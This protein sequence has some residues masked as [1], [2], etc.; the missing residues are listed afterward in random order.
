MTEIS[1]TTVV[2]ALRASMKQVERLRTE[3][4]ELRAAQREPIAIVGMGCRYP[5]GV[6]SADQLWEL[7]RDGRD[8]IGE[9]PTDRG[10]EI[11]ELFDPE[12][13]V[14][15]KTYTRWGGF[16]DGAGD[17][18]AGFFGISPREALGMDPQ[19]RLLLE[20]SWE[21][22]E[23][24][25]IDPQRLRGTNTGVFAGLAAFDRYGPGGFGIPATAASVVSGRVAYALG[26]A[27]PAISVDTACS[28]S[29]VALHLA[30]GSLRSGECE[31]ALAGGVT[32]MAT[33]EIFV[34]FSRQRGLSPDGRCRS[35]GARAEGTGWGEGAGVVVLERLSRARELGH[36][37]LGMVTG[38]AV[39][40]DGASNGLTAPNGPAQQRV[41]RAALAAAGLGIGDVDVVEGHGTATRLG[42][43]VEI[44]AL[45]AT[46]G[47]RGGSASP[48]WLGSVKSNV[49]H[50]QAAAG[51]AG[52]IKMVQAMRHGVL[53][54]SLHCE[55]PSP[56][57]DW[58]SGN[59][60][61]L[62]RARDW[63]TPEGR[64]RRAGV[65]SFGISGTN[66]H[67]ILEQ[68]P[69]VAP[70]PAP[71]CPAVLEGPAAWALSARSAAALAGQARRL[72]EFATA[73]I[74]L[75]T[76]AIGQALGGRA[77][78]EHRA[79]VF[80]RARDELL[81]ALAPLADD[82][83]TGPD[84][85]AQQLVSGTAAVSAPDG[86][87]LVFGGQGSQW[88]GMGRELLAQSPVFAASMRDCEQALAPHVDWSLTRVL[89][90]EDALARVDVVQPALWAVMVS[91]AR[92]WQAAGVRVGAVVGH[93]QGEI[94]AACVA[95]VLS[96]PDAA[97]VVALRARELRRLA[98]TGGMVAVQASP[99]EVRA[100]LV[101]G[102]DIAAVNGPQSVVVSGELEPLRRF[103]TTA[104][105]AGLRVRWLLVDY[106]A[107][108]ARIDALET[109]LATALG[110]IAPLPGS[111]ELYSTV[112]GSRIAATELDTAYWI[113]NLRR[114]VLFDAAVR[115]LLDDGY[116]TFLE[117]SPH[118]LLLA[119]ITET[120][121]EVD[122]ALDGELVTVGSLR[123]GDGSADALLRNLAEAFVSG[124]DVDWAAVCPSPDPRPVK[125]PTYAFDRQ[126]Y[127]LPATGPATRAATGATP[128]PHPLLGVAVEEPGSGTVVLTG[129]WSAARHPWLADHA[130]CGQAVFPATGFVDLA[131]A[132]G[133]RV[134][135]PILRELDVTAALRIPADS[136]ISVR[137]VLGPPGAPEPSTRT[138]A[139]HS[140]PDVDGAAEEWM[141]NAE[142]V[143]AQPD[144]PART[145]T[146]DPIW[147]PA[148]AR[149][150]PL[151]DFYSR[152]AARGYEYGP[153]FQRVAGLWQRGEE[154]FAEAELL[155]H[156]ATE[157]F[158][159]HPALF[160][161]ILHAAVDIAG[162]D[163]GAIMLPF[164][165]HGV[166]LHATGATRVRAHIR[167]AGTGSIALTVTDTAGQK[168][169]SVDSLLMRPLGRTDLLARSQHAAGLFGLHWVPSTPGPVERDTVTVV[170]V[171]PAASASPSGAHAVVA[172][173]LEQVRRWLA[174]GTGCL[175]VVT[176]GAVAAPGE[177]VTD[178]AGAAVWGLV[179][180]AR[181]E[182]SARLVLAD[183]DDWT[184][185]PQGLPQW[186]GDA[187]REV[188]VRGGTVYV[189]RVV[190]LAAG[191][192][193]PELA[194]GTV[195]I[196]GGTG[197]L[198][199][200]IARH[201]V[202]RHGVRR[203]VL[204]SRRGPD[205]DGADTVAA[206]L[207]D[208]GARVRVVSCD[209][210]Q[211]DSVRHLLAEIRAHD[212]LAGVVHAAGVLD[213]GVVESLSSDR[214]AAVL[215]P[216]VDGA[217]HLH[218]WTAD[219]PPPLFAL[220]SSA[221][222]VLGSAGQAAY[223]AAN[224]FLDGLASYRRAQG[225]PAVSVAW[226]LWERA[227]GM[228][229]GLG[230]ADRSRIRR[231]G[232]APMSTDFGSAV[233][234]AVIAADE[235]AVLGVRWDMRALRAQSEQGS[236]PSLFGE[237]V[238]STRPRATAA[239]ALA[240][241]RDRLASM[242]I[243]ERLAVLL[244]TVRAEAAGVLGFRSAE[245]V[246]ADRSF[247]D[248]GLDSLGAVQLRDR[249]GRAVGLRLPASA[250]FDY[251]TP[252]ELTRH[253]VREL[254][255]GLEAAPAPE[256]AAPSDGADPVVI[257]GMGCRYPGGVRSADEF[258]QL[259]VDG[260]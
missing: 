183:V 162:T 110:E 46:Y 70:R 15:G 17:F 106:A 73:E 105:A 13:G 253:V 146:P 39:N 95:G 100:R 75:D 32:V 199:A 152:L 92:V 33:P 190:R 148:G 218:R 160:D 142:G 45:L 81:T 108:S 109:D 126:R 56:H 252:R 224:G 178:P 139:I 196:T 136:A 84:P 53:P 52:V 49:G 64:P 144:P 123:R 48:V 226:G 68:P 78:F 47:R 184:D 217:W 169:V 77:V 168:V 36:T 229:N 82:P 150:V 137:V 181:A 241:L 43:P 35:Y 37:V 59:V 230:E 151:P 66:A 205:A 128:V 155:A 22:L 24:A 188:A 247:R 61:L 16:L 260:R 90:D 87:V 60:R 28:S 9:L 114:P 223:A 251:P 191:A 38:S 23:D 246:P 258:W 225:L 72:R 186:I 245:A 189:P 159:I 98:G 187:E 250:V 2:S 236:L 220:F 185:L 215:R 194:R 27:G 19:Q 197:G 211:S 118:A 209:V 55:Q 145:E 65:S 254:S 94:A 249:V 177:A 200:E 125:L 237:L 14:D 6:G 140:R 149:P 103:A 256:G 222:G 208:L 74:D 34:E 231:M 206:E 228:T 18:D 97:R 101:D 198:G 25:S 99:H 202:L 180:S 161:A 257:V 143:V 107:H 40:Q 79:V 235:P 221:A 216:K 244:E 133:D 134:G 50:T 167:P 147:P 154:V 71:E 193:M 121:A 234:D 88:T 122:D 41:I 219:D 54:K 116:R 179:R 129:S 113:R 62:D 174:E 212:T 10:W 232:V 141:L 63:E 242:S 20:V 204:A 4:R 195:L 214:L 172:A 42:D 115:A 86:V 5:G 192:R 104:D 91:L 175:V 112:S 44:G 29:L 233:F 7:V 89:G 130:V 132:A 207:A 127:W 119:S 156:T 203:L 120:G 163:D 165:W 30:C 8:A 210:T 83:S 131:I 213:D 170:R 111:V 93:S 158:G 21:A 157:G 182:T 58:A 51:V 240:G 67:L 153:Q 26:L 135:H 239:T 176:R 1:E 171:E 227:T 3:N 76:R 164:A 259:V 96:L 124:V 57:V 117:V 248:L 173:A 11:D 138:L 69:E 166:A 31:L 255:G 12:P 243:A 85:L 201:L 102:I 80:G 238:P